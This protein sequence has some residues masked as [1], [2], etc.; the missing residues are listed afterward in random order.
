MSLSI[1]ELKAQLANTKIKGRNGNFLRLDKDKPV[2]VH[3][4]PGNDSLWFRQVAAHWLG[5]NRINCANP[6]GEGSPCYICDRIKE[7]KEELAEARKEHEGDSPAE[8]A[9]NAA[10]FAAVEEA[11]RRISARRLFAFNVLVRGEEMPKTFEAPWQIFNSIYTMFNSAVNDYEID[12]TDP[13]EST[14][15][16]LLRTG[17]G[18]NGTR[19]S[20]T[21]APRGVALFNGPEAES[22]V[23][24]LLSKMLNL[25][26]HYK[27]PEKTELVTAWNTYTSGEE[28][29]TIKSEPA[30]SPA[31]APPL[32]PAP[33]KTPPSM[34]RIGGKPVSP[35][36]FKSEPTV[37]PPEPEPEEGE[38]EGEPEEESELE[39]AE[40]SSNGHGNGEELGE[41]P[42]PGHI[43]TKTQASLA[44]SK[45]LTRLKGKK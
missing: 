34:S 13:H 17:T 40:S 5:K 44:S 25:D 22:K 10:I 15:F 12:I 38:G 21:A 41:E 35:A 30:K 43:P 32:R 39:P 23:A 19:Y 18:K 36:P 8:A 28:T 20:A 1:E 11:I 2:V 31:S 9:E 14:P 33:P 37:K 6:D 3:V 29:G 27:C 26:A 24:A 16:T 45:L 4:L 42:A 7:Q